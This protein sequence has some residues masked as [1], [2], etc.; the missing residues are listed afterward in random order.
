MK[1]VIGN[2]NYSS[3]SLRPWLLLRH[4]SL[5]FDELPISLG[6]KQLSEHLRQFSPSARVPV[7]VDGHTTVWDSLAICEYI[8]EQYL[9]GRGWPRPVAARAKARAVVAEMHAGFAALRSE[10]PMNCRAL[11]RIELSDAA[12]R[13]IARI[14]E[15][16][17]Q[18]Q[19][20]EL[21][22]W[23]FGSF[24]IADCFFAPVAFRIQTYGIHLSQPASE[25]CEHLLNH[26]GMRAWKAAALEEKEIVVDDEVGEDILPSIQACS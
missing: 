18:T 4:F 11:R 8:N 15:I 22:S 16:W 9:E 21:G 6:E 25:Y 10:M 17:S 23:L 12:K 20:Q 14:D 13:D 24:S 7:L 26:N 5:P 1:L 3:W 19:H 2:K